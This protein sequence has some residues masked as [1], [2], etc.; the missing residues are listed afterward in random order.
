MEEKSLQSMLFVITHSYLAKCFGQVAHMGIHPR[1]L[2][3][4]KILH[5]K[6]G[7]SQSELCKR[8]CI[9]PSTVTVSLKR[10]EKMDLVRR[11]PDERDQRMIRVYLTDKGKEIVQKTKGILEEY[12]KYMLEGLS[13]A[14]ICLLRRMLTQIHSNLQQ[15]PL[16]TDELRKILEEKESQ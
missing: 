15:I 12:E 4:L 7:V 5:K 11:E 9:K 8:L 3:M 16:D 6:D 10:M 2:P 14:E 13:E 1:Q